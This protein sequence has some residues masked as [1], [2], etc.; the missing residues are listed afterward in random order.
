MFI[1]ETN[2]HCWFYFLPMS[3]IVTLTTAGATVCVIVSVSDQYGNQLHT[4][5]VGNVGKWCVLESSVP[6]SLETHSC[7]SPENKQ[8]TQHPPSS[9]TS[10]TVGGS[11][12]SLCPPSQSCATTTHQTPCRSCSFKSHSEVMMVSSGTR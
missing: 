3:V 6:A 2:D 9:R 11:V 5:I 8:Q 1:F 7:C 10:L 12:F 4:R